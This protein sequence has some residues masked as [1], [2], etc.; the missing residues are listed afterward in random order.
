MLHFFN[1][2]F[3]IFKVRIIIHWEILHNDDIIV[4]MLF[5]EHVNVNMNRKGYP[6]VYFPHIIKIFCD[7]SIH[8]GKIFSDKIIRI[9]IFFDT[10]LHGRIFF[11]TKESC[12]AYS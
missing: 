12:D 7:N 2:D 11:D 10:I 8:R 4:G 6:K 5:C 3:F 1:V 9:K